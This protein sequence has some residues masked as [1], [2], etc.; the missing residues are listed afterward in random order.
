MLIFDLVIISSNKCFLEALVV[1][2]EC[3]DLVVDNNSSSNKKNKL[4]QLN[5]I[6]S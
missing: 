2:E 4:I 1:L 5:I 6:N 3:L